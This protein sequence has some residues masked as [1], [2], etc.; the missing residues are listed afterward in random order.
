[1]S[2]QQRI[3]DFLNKWGAFGLGYHLNERRGAQ[4]HF[5]ELCA[6]L[7]VPAPEGG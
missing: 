7:E 2:L 3:L 5:V 1:M 4:Q 6:V